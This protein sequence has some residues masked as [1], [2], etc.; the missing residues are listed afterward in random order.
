MNKSS[1]FNEYVYP[2][3]ENYFLAYNNITNSIA[4]I[5]SSLQ[6]FFNGNAFESP[7]DK[8]SSD[9]L[10]QLLADG[11]IVEDK[12]DEQ[13]IARM[14]HYDSI[15]DRTLSVTLLA[16]EECNFR[17]KYCYEQFAGGNM[18]PWVANLLLSI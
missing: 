17:C 2:N 4:R 15:Y 7:L 14:K 11:F 12:T 1:G 18:E 3:K 13:A 16:S 8:H 10:Q 5:P 9:I 6:H